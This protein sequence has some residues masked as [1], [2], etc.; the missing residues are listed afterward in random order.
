MEPHGLIYLS[1]YV[2]RDLRVRIDDFLKTCDFN[3]DGPSGRKVVQYGWLYDYTRKCVTTPLEPI[4]EL[5]TELLKGIPE[6]NLIQ[7]I[8]N[9]YLPGEGIVAHTDSRDFGACIYCF[10]FGSGADMEFTRDGYPKYTLHPEPYSLYVMTGDSRYVW[11]HA[12]PRRKSDLVNGSKKQR[13][14]RYSITFRSL[15]TPTET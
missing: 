10:T 3:I 7:C 12:M 8:I 2:P 13:N 5:L 9:R 1:D 6:H 11:K 14:I 15:Q 4:P